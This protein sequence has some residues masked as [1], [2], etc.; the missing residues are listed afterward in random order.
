V[1]ETIE[2][3]A[4]LKTPRSEMHRIG[5][6]VDEVLNDLGL[7]NVQ[8][9]IIGQAFGGPGRGISGGERK[10]VSVAQE[11]VTRPPLIFLDEPTSGM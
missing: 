4:R 3:A 1:R 6:M 8:H 5:S 11:L 7:T 10:R 9:S 2:F